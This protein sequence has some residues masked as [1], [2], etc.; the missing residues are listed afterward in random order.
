MT[1]K[2]KFLELQ[3][4]IGDENPSKPLEVTEESARREFTFIVSD[5]TSEPSMNFNCYA[6]LESDS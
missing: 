5:D 2:E 4:M 1:L 3:R 6:K